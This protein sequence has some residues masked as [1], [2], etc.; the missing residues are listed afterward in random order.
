MPIADKTI[1]YVDRIASAC[2]PSSTALFQRIARIYP[3]FEISGHYDKEGMQHEYRNK[4]VSENLM[5]AYYPGHLLTFQV[6]HIAARQ[7]KLAKHDEKRTQSQE[8]ECIFQ[9]RARRKIT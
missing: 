6:D 3:R 9:N 5:E 8:R 1:M 2:R 7:I 4:D